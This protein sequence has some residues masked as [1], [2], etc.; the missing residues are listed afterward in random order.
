MKRISI[1]M[2]LLAGSIAIGPAAA[3]NYA[4]ATKWR[5]TGETQIDC[6]GH[7]DEA[8]RRAGFD[9]AEP[10]SQSIMGRR[11]DYTAA[12]RCVTEQRMVFFVVAG[13][14]PGEVNRL[15]DAIYNVF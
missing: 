7:A 13:P 12:V 2:A 5:V 3:D 4:V 15:L 9:L 1:P 10:G 14:A 8:I 6:L 11:G